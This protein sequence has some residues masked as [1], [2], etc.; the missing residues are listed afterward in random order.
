MTASSPPRGAKTTALTEV[1]VD[2][3]GYIFVPY[4]GRIKASGN[5]PEA[6]R[7]IITSKLDAQTPDPPGQRDAPR[8]AMARPCR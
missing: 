2:G 3:S 6:L 8:G 7:R 5:S 4:A 1:Q